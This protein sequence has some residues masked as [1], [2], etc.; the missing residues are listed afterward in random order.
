[1]SKQRIIGFQKYDL[2]PYTVSGELGDVNEN[3]FYEW[4]GT[5]HSVKPFL[6]LPL[7]EGKRRQARIQQLKVE[8]TKQQAK[9][10]CDYIVKLKQIIDVSGIK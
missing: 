3:G 7:H 10:R 2:F 5:G 4:K 9:V 1:M 8:Y 6:I